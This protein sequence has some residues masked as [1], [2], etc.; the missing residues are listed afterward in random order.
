MACGIYKITNLINNK[1]YIG[2]SINL[3]RRLKEHKSAP[4]DNMAIHKAIKKYGVENFLFEILEECFEEQ[5]DEKECYWIDYYNSYLGNGY[6]A[7]PGG[8][9]ASHPV[10][11]SNNQL[12]NI[13][14]D[15]Q[16]N[17]E[18]SL[19]EI[20]N[21]YNVS[22]K[23]ISD[24][25]N[26]RSRKIETLMYPLRENHFSSIIV[27]KKELLALLKDTKGDFNFIANKFNVHHVTIR[28]WCKNYNLPT[29]RESYGYIDKQLYHS[30]AINQYNKDTNEFIQSFDSIAEAGR[31]LNLN[32]KAISRALNSKSHISQGYIWKRKI[33]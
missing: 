21:K 19:K 28:N 13:I 15:L 30:T 12:L 17:L 6:N 18:L 25:N 26:G 4:N 23:T 14:D 11:I 22:E 9:G 3:Q 24:I 7:A 1:V 16:N 5:L 29:T 31:I 2:K 32:S 33:D 10:K 20:A 8:E 27:S